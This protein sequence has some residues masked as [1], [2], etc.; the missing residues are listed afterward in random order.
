MAGPGGAGRCGE[1]EAGPA[2]GCLPAQGGRSGS[3][4][5][6]GPGPGGSRERSGG[7]TRG[8]EQRSRSDRGRRL[9]PGGTPSPEDSGGAGRV[10]AGTGA[11][12]GGERLP[13]GPDTLSLL[14]V[15]LTRPRSKGGFAG[16]QTRG[17]EVSA[18]HP[19]CPPFKEARG[20]GGDGSARG[21]ALEHL[22]SAAAPL[23]AWAAPSSPSSSA[24]ADHGTKF[25]FDPVPSLSHGRKLSV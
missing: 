18:W 16:S 21:T 1:R 11:G 4:A 23:D 13:R 8:A 17:L 15:G 14:P 2:P 6:K 9:R 7:D 24:L 12:T 19:A 5:G 20:A 25:G 10:R 3:P 22:R